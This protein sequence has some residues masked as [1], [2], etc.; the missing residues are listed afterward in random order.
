MDEILVGRLH[1]LHELI[2]SVSCHSS[3]CVLLKGIVL[4]CKCDKCSRNLDRTSIERA[5]LERRTGGNA[6]I[7]ARRFQ[8]RCVCWSD[9]CHCSI[10]HRGEKSMAVR[11][12]FVRS[13]NF[14]NADFNEE[15]V[16]C[17]P[18]SFCKK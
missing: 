2:E 5:L 10:C 6:T 4:L 1:F 12:Q 18:F 13:Q 16:I 9:R 11:H 7:G 14:V 17:C 3:V 8:G 15:K